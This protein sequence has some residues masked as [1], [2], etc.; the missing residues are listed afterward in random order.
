MIPDSGFICRT[1]GSTYSVVCAGPEYLESRG[2]PRS[3]EDLA[4]HT[5]LQLQDPAFPRG[6]EIEGLD[7]EA[8][9]GTDAAFKVNVA[10]A[11]AQ[12][13]KANMGIVLIPGY[14]AAAAI[15]NRELVRVL[16]EVK[17]HLRKISVIYP[18]RRFLDAKVRTWIDFLKENLQKRQAIDELSLCGSSEA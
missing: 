6:W 13:A 11:I 1:I 3:L 2:V 17:A 4:R 12:A 8:F 16:P 14:V 7:T 15:R 10:D 18:S 9:G 5:C